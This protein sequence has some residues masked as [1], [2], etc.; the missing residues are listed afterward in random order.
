MHLWHHL[1]Q[2]DQ[3]LLSFISNLPHPYWLNTFMALVSLIG[4]GG[5]ILLLGSL[6]IG[7]LEERFELL[8]DTVLTVTYTTLL[9]EFGLKPLFARPRPPAV[10]QLYTTSIFASYSFPSGH[11]TTAFALAT[12]LAR[13]SPRHSLWLFLLALL[14]GAS[15]VYLG[16]HYPLDVIAGIVLGTGIGEL[17]HRLLTRPSPHC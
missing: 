5:G 17:A 4:T 7:Y 13:R 15:R 9:T 3:A 12:L 1:I 2:I 16:V 11:T 6:F 14:I 8:P 10:Y